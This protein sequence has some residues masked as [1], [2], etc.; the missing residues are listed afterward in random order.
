MSPASCSPRW[1]CRPTVHHTAKRAAPSCRP[2]RRRR[3]SW[4][5]VFPHV[6]V[7]TRGVPRLRVALEA[8]A[9]ALAGFRRRHVRTRPGVLKPSG[10]ASALMD[11]STS[12]PMPPV[13]EHADDNWAQTSGSLAENA[14][15]FGI[16]K[17]RFEVLGTFSRLFENRVPTWRSFAAC[18]S[19]CS[20][21]FFPIVAFMR[22]SSRLFGID[23]PYAESETL[24]GPN[25]RRNM[26]ETPNL[27]DDSPNKRKLVPSRPHRSARRLPQRTER[28]LSAM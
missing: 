1:S 6:V 7:P 28:G 21:F 24:R 15:L 11:D 13:A 10:S 4:L 22:I 20:R 17:T 5:L 26:S 27:L 3:V 8:L 23:A 12:K 2:P 19:V 16:S 9:G 18:I 25:K 14:R